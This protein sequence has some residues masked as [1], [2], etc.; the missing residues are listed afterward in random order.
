[1]LNIIY[2]RAG[3]R[4]GD[5]VY[6]RI[7][8]FVD[9]KENEAFSAGVSQLL[10]V[11]RHY[12][13]ESER[14]LCETCGS[15]A[16]RYCEV[17][18]LERLCIRVKSEYGGMTDIQAI[19]DDMNRL[20]LMSVAARRVFASLGVLA[21]YISKPDFLSSLLVLWDEF[22]SCKIDLEGISLAEQTYDAELNRKLRDI[23]L[24]FSSFRLTLEARGGFRTMGEQLCDALA[25]S[26]YLKG[27]TIYLYGFT[28]FT[29]Q[30]YDLLRLFL[31]DAGEVYVV[32]DC[33]ASS[34]ENPDG[35]P[36]DDT[37]FF[38]QRR[39]AA[40]LKR[41]CSTLGIEYAEEEI[42]AVSGS[43]GREFLHMEENLFKLTPEKYP[44]PA[45]SISISSHSSV[46]KECE[47]AA[48]RILEGVRNGGYKFRDFAL[49]L[50]DYKKYAG[51]VQAVFDSFGIPVFM[52][53]MDSVTRKPVIAAILSVISMISG[54]FVKRDVISYIKTGLSKL[55]FEEAAAL[56]NYMETWSITRK[57][58]TSDEDWDFNPRGFSAELTDAAREELNGLNRL[59]RL[60][61]KPFSDF[62]SAI[63]PETVYTSKQHAAAFFELLTGIGI[64]RQIE[65]RRED[66][67]AR[68]E[69]EL[70]DEYAQLWQLVCDILDSI[71]L[72]LGESTLT[73]YEFSSFFTT[74]LESSAVGAIPAQLDGVTAGEPGRLRHRDVKILL[75]LGAAAGSFPA[76]GK[77]VSLL[78]D[79]NREE[80]ISLG[81]AVEPPQNE[82]IYRETDL[83]YSVMTLPD[84]YLYISWCTEGSSRAPSYIA[85]RV[86]GIFSLE[87]LQPD[88]DEAL[89]SARNPALE[90]G[91]SSLGG[92]APPD[93]AAAAAYSYFSSKPE[94][95]EILSRAR[96]AAYGAADLLSPASVAG[97][98]GDTLRLTASR[99]DKLASCRFAYFMQYGL[100]A[101][102][103]RKASL[104]ALET[105][106]LLHSVL[107][108]CVK[109]ITGRGG[110]A[111]VTLEDAYMIANDRL[112]RY[113][114]ETLGGV[115]GKSK[116]VQY[117][118]GRIRRSLR[119]IIKNI[120]EEMLV[121]S[122]E[123][124]EFELE[125]GEGGELDPIRYENGGKPFELSGIVDRVDG[126]VKDGS[127]Y[128]RV[129]DYKSGMKKFSLRDI[130]H[131]L[132]LQMLIY[133]FALEANGAERFGRPALGA[134]VLY[135]P[136]KEIVFSGERGLSAESVKQETMKM[137]KRNGLV[138]ADP[139]ITQAMEHGNGNKFVPVSVGKDSGFSA[140]SSVAT[141]EQFGRLKRHIDG[142]LKE[143][144]RQLRAGD[145]SL[146]PY[147][148]GGG[149]S[150]CRFCDFRTACGFDESN[151][152]DRLR[153][154]GAMKSSEFWEKLERDEKNG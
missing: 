110:F 97:L 75:L 54:G 152:R 28:E 120:Y 130:W 12:S 42:T 90:L 112:D 1:L 38:G 26:G 122:F 115:T 134:G 86:A 101:R 103:P 27:K 19:P 136:V 58:W 81:V 102:V 36:V 59:R 124:I 139:D 100:R 138:L 82:L 60:I 104:D 132:G 147:S 78:S 85:A 55:T 153:Y 105:G 123:P 96:S 77:R 48:D 7:K 66:Y 47:Y 99:L 142:L 91:L 11:P 63:D 32:F 5:A 16:S 56:E 89:L 21:P 154:L 17:L 57:L 143:M 74:I 43:K 44:F 2:G 76:P 145:A 129:V 3:R 51:I 137:L 14:R 93:T 79:S 149:N 92:E 13:H 135:A 121:S 150:A 45:S 98:Y 50:A 24:I 148:F 109:E 70:R 30:E 83:C 4:P 25:G 146:T 87:T 22:K 84:E 64:E 61:F 6:S 41:M 34:P 119:G 9:A 69:T 62:F 23:S 33:A 114:L 18:T 71:Y 20:L 72:V 94:Y 111:A 106:N 15:A 95:G 141:L 52:D 49:G 125:F 31:C 126:F 117:L 35:S 116:R 37:L 8:A 67:S 118:F 88:N 108:G 53:S 140:S 46:W 113:A 65:L 107:E 133:L 151:G 39:A 68:G 80:L 128:I 29:S 73:F 127:L 131:G 40:N 144:V 10:I